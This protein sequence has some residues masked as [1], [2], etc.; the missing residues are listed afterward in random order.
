MEVAN[1]EELYNFLFS[2]GLV[3]ENSPAGPNWFKDFRITDD[4]HREMLADCCRC[5]RQVCRQ[6]NIDYTGE[7]PEV[8]DQRSSLIAR[9]KKSIREHLASA[10][11]AD[12]A[13]SVQY[14]AGLL[15]V[16]PN[17]LNA[18]V[19]KTTGMPAITHIHIQVIEEAKLLLGGTD[20]PVKAISYRL[21]FR[22][23]AH[24]C[25]FFRKY[26]FL[27]PNEYRRHYIKRNKECA[28]LDGLLYSLV[29]TI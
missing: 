18:V 6:L 15:F 26:T 2:Q 8:P 10:E 21:A 27:T 9:F 29:S 7:I 16:H 17:Y 24:F 28:K 23:P 11:V 12:D 25:T 20:L 3:T 4:V 14:Y 22:E 13:R 1:L 19:K 5:L